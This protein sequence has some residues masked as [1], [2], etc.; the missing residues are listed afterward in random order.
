MTPPPSP[1]LKLLRSLLLVTMLLT[2]LQNSHSTA[3]LP[4][5][6]K[7]VQYLFGMLER[8]LY[9]RAFSDQKLQRSHDPLEPIMSVDAADLAF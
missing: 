9:R 3:M 2:T 1:P 7:S 8:T 5:T 6:A 4:S